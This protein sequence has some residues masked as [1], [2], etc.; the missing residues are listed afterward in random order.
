MQVDFSF[1][2]PGLGRF[3]ANAFNQRSSLAL[4]LRV[5]PFRVR[6]LEELGAPAR[7]HHAAEQA[8][9]HRARRWARPVRASRRRWRR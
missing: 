9:R 3:R 8:V 2:I 4:A 6:S 5:V 7:V 1:G